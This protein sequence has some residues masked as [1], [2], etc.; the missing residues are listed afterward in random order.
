M[1][2]LPK[3]CVALVSLACAATT[4]RAYVVNSTLDLPDADPSDSACATAPPN[5]VCTLRA[6]VMQANA[7]P[8]VDTIELSNTTYGFTRVG[9]DQSGELGDLDVTDD[10]TIFGNGATI[11]ANG[12]TT[13][14]RAFE[15]VSGSLSLNNVTVR[16]GA[17]PS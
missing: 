1:R 6:A 11:D 7:H 4:A 16:N 5:P 10:V 17:S 9:Y 14:D 15:V 12:T 13:G 3:I 2:A 8:G